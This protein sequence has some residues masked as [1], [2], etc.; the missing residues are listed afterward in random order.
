MRLTHLLAALA[1]VASPALAETTFSAG[2]TLEFYH[3]PA[4]PGSKEE[5]DAS[6]YGEAEI[7]GFYLGASALKSNDSTL[8]EFSLGAGYRG[9][10]S[11]IGYDVALTRYVYPRDSLSNYTELTLGLSR[12]FDDRLSGSLD[13][14]YDLSNKAA[15]AYIG[16]S[17]AATDKLGLSANFGVYEVAGL[18]NESEW[19]LGATYA[20]TDQMS[21]DLR[22][23][24]GTDYTDGYVGLIF[25]W[26]TSFAN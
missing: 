21:A 2:G 13:F 3:D 16:A 9:D 18:S 4:G 7:N 6:I 11:G 12:D 14:G 8:D 20:L 1:C 17:Y 26:D 23:Y 10:M 22:W 25:S 24:D 5:I 15:N 19:D